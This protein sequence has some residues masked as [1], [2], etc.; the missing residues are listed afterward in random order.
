VGARH[1]LIKGGHL[2]GEAVD[3]FFDGRSLVELRG[4]RIS[5]PHTHGTGCTLSA[6][7][8]VELARGSRAL[9]AVKTAKA[10]ITAAIELSFPLGAGHGPVNLYAAAARQISPQASA[11]RGVFLR[12]PRRAKAEPCLMS[13]VRSAFLPAARVSRR[14]ERKIATALFSSNGT[15]VRPDLKGRLSARA[16]NMMK[17][18]YPLR[19]CERFNT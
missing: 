16:Y 2:A 5:T 6:I 10:L 9:E 8:A 13:A 18:G 4:A 3:V 1:V 7:L 11:R 12:P 19:R 14:K 15:G 17:T